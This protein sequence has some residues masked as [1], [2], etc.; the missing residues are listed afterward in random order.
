MRYITRYIALV[1][2]C[3]LGL[4]S[5]IALAAAPLP[6]EGAFQIQGLVTSVTATPMTG[7]CR[8]HPA[9]RS[10]AW[11]TS[12]NSHGDGAIYRVS[13]NAATSFGIFTEVFPKAKKHD[14]APSG[15][16]SFGLEGS[17]LATGTFSTSYTALDHSSFLAV[18]T[19]TYTSPTD[20]TTS[21]V[22]VD[23][24]TF[25]RVTP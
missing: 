16:Y 5:T 7:T 15:S 17:T 3:G 8:H 2:A 14:L 19:L 22:E 18:N 24:V 10:R 11:F 4:Q 13:E 25:I 23:Q 1:A 9:I 12:A 6:E 21:C 20:S